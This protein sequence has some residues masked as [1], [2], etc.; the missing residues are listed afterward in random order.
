MASTRE[1]VRRLNQAHEALFEEVRRIS[2]RLAAIEGGHEA[3]AP[4]S[5]TQLSADEQLLMSSTEREHN[6]VALMSVGVSVELKTGGA[7][8]CEH[9]QQADGISEDREQASKQL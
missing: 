7:D 8:T 4:P 6:P 9:D 3:R 5:S 2:E 1:R